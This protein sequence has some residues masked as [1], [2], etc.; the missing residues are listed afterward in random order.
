M[1]PETN[2]NQF[3]SQYLKTF[4]FLKG[5][6]LSDREGIQLNS[7]LADPQTEGKF[8]QISSML[9]AAMNQANDNIHKV[10]LRVSID[11]N[12]AEG[13]IPN[14]VLPRIPNSAAKYEKSRV[15]SDF[16]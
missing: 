8:W 12:W 3:L 1:Q 4:S 2:R 5:I 15:D 13:I 10:R 11:C 16:F 14:T 9:I 6:I 7:A